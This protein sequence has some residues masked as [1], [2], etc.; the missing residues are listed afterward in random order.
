MTEEEL[1][2]LADRFRQKLALDPEIR[3]LSK[4][5]ADGTADFSDTSKLF[6]RR[7]VMLREYTQDTVLDLAPE[8]RQRLV[9][10]LLHRGYDDTTE[11]LTIV[12]ETLDKAQGLHLNPVV[13]KY[14]A[15]RVVQVAHAL[16]D[17]TVPDEKIVRRAGAPVANVNMSFH[18][19]YMKENAKIRA[20]L[21]FKCYLNR[22]A[23]AGC[24]KWCTDIAGRYVY[25]DQ[26][27][28]VFRRH[29]NCGCTVTFENGRERQ[30]VWSKRT[31]QASPLE[32][33][34]AGFKPVRNSRA[35]AEKLE[36]NAL[37]RLTKPGQGDIINTRSMA[38]PNKIRWLPKGEE[39]SSDARKELIEYAKANKIVLTGI[40]HSDVDPELI[41]ESVDIAAS[42][43]ALFPEINSNPEMPFTIKVVNGL[44]SNTLA[45]TTRRKNTNVL[46]LNANAYRDANKLAN[47]YSKL[48]EDKWFVN[49]TDKRS[50]IKH[51]IGHMYQ[52]THKI[53]DQAIMETA[54]RVAG[55]DDR[56]ALFKFLKDNLSEYSSSYKD[57]SEIISE[58]F[59]DY[60]SK[61]N[62]TEFSQK[63]MKALKE[64]G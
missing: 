59:S 48:V 49:G 38:Q 4:K 43:L 21:G 8:D 40:R 11:A 28:D 45:Q 62:P 54:M 60:F 25:G 20:K 41:R 9:E 29:D 13:P 19:D 1:K 14:P 15:E 39:L 5:I 32:V 27:E 61:E 50:I 2:A 34:R 35:Q 64:M 3:S 23:A 22:V 18:D 53:T 51:E 57:G 17:P 33:N 42:M 46:Q 58:V 47:E 6:W 7:S 36:Q 56:K 12:Q 63:F 37:G 26:P 30:D 31:W 24:C 16:M 52:T 55:I 10:A 44:D